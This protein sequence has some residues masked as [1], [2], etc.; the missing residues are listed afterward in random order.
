DRDLPGSVPPLAEHA[1]PTIEQVAADV[2]R[3]DRQRHTGPT[4]GSESWLAAVV[5]A[6]DERLSL[7][8]RSLFVTQHLS[9]LDGVD[10]DIERVRVEGELQAAGPGLPSVAPQPTE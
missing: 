9:A 2:R 4:T 1:L 6:Y 10:R 3:L 7:A 8:C 5:R